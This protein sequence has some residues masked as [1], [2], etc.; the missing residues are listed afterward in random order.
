M[1]R[2]N[3]QKALAD[4]EDAMRRGQSVGS[5]LTALSG[6][7]RLTETTVEQ[8]AL[9]ADRMNEIAGYVAQIRY[10]LGHLRPELYHPAVAEESRALVARY[11]DLEGR[12]KEL[13]NDRM[14]VIK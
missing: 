10:L 9:G 13:R 11:R 12:V 3:R 4:I 7:L 2:T 1:E 14:A 5:L 6:L 8:D